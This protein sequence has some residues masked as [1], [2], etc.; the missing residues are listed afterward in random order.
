[1]RRLLCGT[2]A[3]SGYVTRVRGL[4]L[5][6]ETVTWRV[7]PSPR[8]GVPGAEVVPV[9]IPSVP[10][11]LPAYYVIT[12]AEAASNLACYDGVRYGQR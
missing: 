4:V 9:S 6:C 12:P 7:R 1:M 10:L 11:A 2:W 8:R 3:C 5:A